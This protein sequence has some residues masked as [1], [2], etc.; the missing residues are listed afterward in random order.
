MPRSVIPLILACWLITLPTPGQESTEGEIDPD[1]V[2]SP[3]SLVELLPPGGIEDINIDFVTRSRT[4][5]E[6]A[7]NPSLDMYVRCIIKPVN[8]QLHFY[9]QRVYERTQRFAIVSRTVYDAQGRFVSY[10]RLHLTADEVFSRTTASL[11]DD[12]LVLQT[13]QQGR[14]QSI[15]SRVPRERFE[16]TVP[17]AWLPLVYAYHFREEHL[18]FHLITLD[19]DMGGR[20]TRYEV[21]D[22]GI[23]QYELSGQTHPAHLLKFDVTKLREQF[24]HATGLRLSYYDRQG[25][26][27][28]STYTTPAYAIKTER[29]THEQAAEAF[30]GLED[31]FPDPARRD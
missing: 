20:L 5:R 28:A 9:R 24:I 31:D 22:L 25:R 18:G 8:G 23:E 16:Q 30:V 13:R 4:L 1:N 10:D 27:L 7:V 2:A 14:S 3:L 29:L 17:S 19:L 26:T 21:D 15:E 6:G 11:E 12:A